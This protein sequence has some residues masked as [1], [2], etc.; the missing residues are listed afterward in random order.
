MRLAQRGFVNQSRGG[1]IM[2][3]LILLWAL[4][5]SCIAMQSGVATADTDLAVISM[6]IA[7]PV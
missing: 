6:N 3:R 5:V 4:A 2:R 1:L 7:N